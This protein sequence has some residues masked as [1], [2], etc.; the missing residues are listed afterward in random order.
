MDKQKL[1]KYSLAIIFACVILAIMLKN[2]KGCSNIESAPNQFMTAANQ[3]R[4]SG[5][6]HLKKVDVYMDFSGS[7]RG[8]LDFGNQGDDGDAVMTSVVSKAMT[9]MN[10]IYDIESQAHCGG[11]TYNQQKCLKALRDKSIYNQN[12]T[13]LD[14]MIDTSCVNLS[15]SSV[16]VIV[17]DMILSYGRRKLLAEQDTFYNKHSKSGLGDAIYA[18]ATRLKKEG[19]E[20]AIL[21]FLS[22]YNAKYYCNYTENLKP[23]CFKGEILKKRPFYVMLIGS[24]ANIIDILAKGIF[25]IAQK[26]AHIYSTIQFNLTNESSKWGLSSRSKDWLFIE[27]PDEIEGKPNESN[28]LCYSLQGQDLDN[29]ASTLTFSFSSLK[30]KIPVFLNQELTTDYNHNIFDDV[31]FV[32]DEY[33]ELTLKMRPYSKLSAT[34]NTTI[35]IV[36]TYDWVTNDSMDDDVNVSSSEMEGKT[37]GIETLV[38]NI[39]KAYETP[40]LASIAEINIVL[41]K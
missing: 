13:L 10:A 21:Q 2:C 23:V 15:D 20:I 7:M 22:D 8:Y 40:N 31:A 19:K 36:T 30:N 6:S 35:R 4:T 14:K 39:S 24:E 17:S 29:D 34:E 38:D 9:K 25:N 16:V 18:T 11:M 32:D 37:W 12:T 33:K 5:N 26:P 27:G 41:T 1:I 3:D 28:L